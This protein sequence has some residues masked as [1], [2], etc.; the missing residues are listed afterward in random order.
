MTI[1]RRCALALLAGLT[2]FFFSDPSS[3]QCS[4]GNRGGGVMPMSTGSGSPLN[5]TSSLANTLARQ[6]AL[7]YQRQQS[8]AMRQLYQRQQQQ[9]M[10]MRMEQLRQ[11]AQ[12]RY[13][14]QQGILAGRLA[15]AEAKRAQRAERIA[16]RLEA[17]DSG[18]SNASSGTMLASSESLPNVEENPFR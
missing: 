13:D 3:A 14:Q 18:Q 16:V 11:L 1:L 17:R 5:M 12:Q 15:R 8:L 10:A 4:G 7:E 6:Q 2:L 9:L